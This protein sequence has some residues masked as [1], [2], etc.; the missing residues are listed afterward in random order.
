MPFIR[1]LNVS[2]HYDA[3]RRRFASLAFR[4]SSDGSGISVV[5]RDCAEE[6]SGTICSHIRTHYASTA[7]TPV[8]FWA[9]PQEQIPDEC[10][11]VHS[12]SGTDLWCH[13]DLTGWKKS[14]AEKTI[15]R[16]PI[17]D[18]QICTDDGVRALSF[19]DLPQG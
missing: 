12:V 16:V 5:E 1:L 8:V 6:H 2:H 10:N 4:P 3:R 11:F 19:D 9:I 14:H 13:Y 15:K 18:A 17:E 7:G